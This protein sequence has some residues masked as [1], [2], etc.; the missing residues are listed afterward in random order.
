[1]RQGA[2]GSTGASRGAPIT[3]VVDVFQ[4]REA[5]HLPGRNG[6]KGEAG[7]QSDQLYCARHSG[8]NW[9]TRTRLEYVC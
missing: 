5:G 6:H 1:M 7:P 4:K 9:L 3:G 8:R 2:A